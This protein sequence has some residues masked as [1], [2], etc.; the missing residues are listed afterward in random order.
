MLQLF[1]IIIYYYFFACSFYSLVH[2]LRQPDVRDASGILA[3]QMDVGIQDRRI[4][5]LAVLPQDSF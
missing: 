4:D 5:G 3:E 1:F 2:V